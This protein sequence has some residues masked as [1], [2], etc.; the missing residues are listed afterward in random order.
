MSG[1]EGSHADKE[2]GKSKDMTDA[3]AK[4]VSVIVVWITICA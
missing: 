3:E 1:D 2:G 4:R